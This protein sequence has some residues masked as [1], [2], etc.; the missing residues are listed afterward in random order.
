MNKYLLLI[1]S[2]FV[3]GSSQSLITDI[4]KDDKGRIEIDFYKRTHKGL[5]KVKTETYH[6]NGQL[7]GEGTYKNGT[8]EGKWI[9]YWE[10]GAVRREGNY[11]DGEFDG[12]FTSYYKS[13]QIDEVKNKDIRNSLSSLLDAIKND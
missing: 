1:L 10:D 13:G 11:R 7:R 9:E 6:K 8:M 5:Q 3:F 4:T 12:Q 2:L